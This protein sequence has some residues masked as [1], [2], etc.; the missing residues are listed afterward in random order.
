MKIWWY[1]Y[2]GDSKLVQNEILQT[3]ISN[4]RNYRFPKI[5][6]IHTNPSEKTASTTR[7]F[8]S[9]MM[10]RQ[11]HIEEVWKLVENK[12][13]HTFELIFRNYSFPRTHRL[14]TNRSEETASTTREILMT[15]SFESTTLRELK[16]MMVQ[17]ELLHTFEL[18]IHSHGSLEKFTESAQTHLRKRPRQQV[19]TSPDRMSVEKQ[20]STLPWMKR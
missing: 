17:N 18:K 9:S 7:G 3:L 6:R 10:F 4:S 12:I 1:P 19:E 14:Y 20:T 13:L 8:F 16:K 15:W 2:S 11:R 5:H